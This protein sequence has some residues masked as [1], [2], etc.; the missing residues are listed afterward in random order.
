MGTLV[1]AGEPRAR[2]VCCLW[3]VSTTRLMQLRLRTLRVHTLAAANASSHFCPVNAS[4]IF[5]VFLRVAIPDLIEEA[6]QGSPR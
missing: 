4:M 6:M 3:R 1:T 2:R 5:R